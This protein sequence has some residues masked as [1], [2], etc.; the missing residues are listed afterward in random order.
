LLLGAFA[1]AALAGGA[2]AQDS[3][4]AAETRAAATEDLQT[5]FEA[6]MDEFDVAQA[7]FWEAYTTAEETGVEV[8]FNSYPPIAFFGRFDELAEAGSLD[9]MFWVLN[10]SP[11]DRI[12][13][14]ASFLERAIFAAPGDERLE[15]TFL[16]LPVWV[17][18]EGTAAVDVL[19]RFLELEDEG[20]RVNAELARANILA[21]L[22][23]DEAGRAEGI[24]ALERLLALP[25]EFRGKEHIAGT[26]FSLQNLEIGMIAPDF[27]TTDVDGSP[28]KLSD[29]RG[30]VT[31][32]EFWGFW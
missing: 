22:E 9:A 24:A 8:D 27:E 23:D 12:G 7:A 17:A 30:M 31:V 5:R 25:E 3:P 13:D 4:P 29:S 2:P 26:L 18:G 1:V 19:D 20:Y 28:L 11:E 14:Y 21:G 32:V 15:R 6:L 16:Y 10:N